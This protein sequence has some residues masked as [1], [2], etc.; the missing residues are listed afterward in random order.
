[1]PPVT[2]GNLKTPS[3]P[4]LK[5]R[6]RSSSQPIDP[7]TLMTSHREG[8]GSEYL[9]NLPTT[10]RET[11]PSLEPGYFSAVQTNASALDELSAH[12]KTTVHKPQATRYARSKIKPQHGV[13]HPTRVF[14]L[15]PRS[16][17]LFKKSGSALSGQDVCSPLEHDEKKELVSNSPPSQQINPVPYSGQ[18]QSKLQIDMSGY[19]LNSRTEPQWLGAP[20]TDSHL[21]QPQASGCMEIVPEPSLQFSRASW[22]DCLLQTYDLRSSPAESTGRQ[23]SALEISRDVFR[24]FKVASFWLHFINVPL[25]F[26]MFHHTEYRAAIQPALVLAILSYSK[27]LQSS[28]DVKGDCRDELERERMWRQ[29]AKL[30]DLAQSS[31]DASYNAGWIDMQLA[32]AAWILVFYETC[33]HRDSSAARKEA[34]IL[35]LDNVIR[36]LGLTNLDATDPRAPT[37][38]PNSVPALGRPRPNGQ[39]N[40]SRS[41][42]SMARCSATYLQNVSP[43]LSPS[44]MIKYGGARPLPVPSTGVR[45][46]S[47]R[48]GSIATKGCPCLALSLSG[49]PEAARCTPEWGTVPR[50]GLSETWAD[51]RKEEARRLVWSSVNLLSGHAASSLSCGTRLLDLHISRPENFALLFTGENEHSSIPEVDAV[52]SGKESTLAILSRTMLLFWA[53]ARRKPWTNNRNP[54]FAP[55]SKFTYTPAD[56]DFAMRAW[57]ETVALEAALDAHTCGFEAT[58]L[59]QARTYILTIRLLVSGAYHP[60]TATSRS[61]CF[62]GTGFTQSDRESAMKW[63]QLQDG[64]AKRLCTV[65][66]GDNPLRTALV[67]KPAMMWFPLGQIWRCMELW[68]LDSSWISA[69]DVALNFLPLLR[70][71]E[72][73]WPCPE[74]KRRS[75]RIVGELEQI[76]NMLGKQ[77]PL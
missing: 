23:E 24:F 27:L 37:F 14:T 22:W 61:L 34:V 5:R 40:F 56:A 9:A 55:T 47:Q 68:R 36:A 17:E 13:T 71:F 26:D 7:M 51:I 41:S 33:G 62:Q 21:H 69:V 16:E 10:M 3:P 39:G 19:N 43:D 6:K 45:A 50:W 4:Q 32:Q 20:K 74:Q 73:I 46:S 63:L 53:C 18:S 31:F 76:C 66:S 60:P 28:G 42:G 48:D 12:S 8:I 35:L 44:L 30:R 52:F 65:L 64:M 11:P 58:S 2:T 25:F 77:M 49:N 70:F 72:K 57:M 75:V 15:V 54:N 59:Y 1:M 67:S 29:S 38:E